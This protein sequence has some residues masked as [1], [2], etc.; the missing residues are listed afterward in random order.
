MAASGYAWPFLEAVRELSSE[1]AVPLID[2]A[3]MSKSLFEE[4]GAEETKTIFMWGAPGEFVHYPGG[5]ADNTHFQEQGAIRI[6]GLI[7]DGIREAAIWPLA[8]FLR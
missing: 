4:L 5:I 8:M 6:A 1:Q 3:A 7:A 2:L